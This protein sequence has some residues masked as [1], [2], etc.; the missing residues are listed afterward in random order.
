M[1]IEMLLFWILDIIIIVLNW[2]FSLVPIIEIPVAWVPNVVG[3]MN[4]ASYFLPVGTL[5]VQAS[6]IFEFI[7]IYL[8]IRL[9]KFI[10][11]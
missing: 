3:I 6:I 7:T 1:I 10:R 11:R 9:I 5:F 8:L 2:I 4:W